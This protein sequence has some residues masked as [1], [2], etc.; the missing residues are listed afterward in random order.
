L[1]V[2]KTIQESEN[3]QEVMTLNRDKAS[4]DMTKHTDK[5]TLEREKIQAELVKS[6]NDVVVSRVN[7]NRYDKKQPNAKPK[8][9]KK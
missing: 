4:N 7:K 6:G 9:K 1:D 8:K 2:L 3:Y 5:M